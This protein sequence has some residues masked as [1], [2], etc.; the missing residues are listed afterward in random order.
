[1]V[2]QW[3]TGP[4]FEEH[5]DKVIGRVTSELR[6][7]NRIFSF[8]GFGVCIFS[9]MWYTLGVKNDTETKGL[10]HDKIKNSGLYKSGLF[11]LVYVYSNNFIIYLKRK[12]QN[13]DKIDRLFLSMSFSAVVR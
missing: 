2:N 9:V 10:N 3:K 4:E 8:F 7:D 12:A 13:H 1:M 6:P 11:C 5:G